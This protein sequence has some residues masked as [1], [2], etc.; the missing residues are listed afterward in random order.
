MAVVGG[1]GK[2]NE[3]GEMLA[4]P[5][6]AQGRPVWGTCAG[7][8]REEEG[9]EGRKRK[10]AAG[11]WSSHALHSAAAKQGPERVPDQ[12]TGGACEPRLSVGEA[13]ACDHWGVEGFRTTS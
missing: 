13:V 4:G 8:N 2:G 1:C 9:C 3:W 6:A 7:S 11:A 10:D 5:G 12:L